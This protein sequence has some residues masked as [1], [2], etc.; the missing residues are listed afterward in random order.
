MAEAAQ[1]EFS[2]T[3][4][5]GTIEWIAKA[6][7]TERV[8]GEVPKE[9]AALLDRPPLSIVWV[10]A[11]HQDRL[12]GAIE[13]FAGPDALV[14]YGLEATR[15][16]FGPVLRPILRG[17]MGLFGATPATIFSRLDRIT[18]V[19]IRGE[20][21][22]FE[23]RSATEGVLTIRAVDRA[24]EVWF[25]A[26][27]GVLLYGFELA[28][29]QGKVAEWKHSPGANEATYRLV[30]SEPREAEVTRPLGGYGPRST[31]SPWSV[32]TSSMLGFTVG[33]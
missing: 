21:Y 8:R 26:W 7:L 24:P 23:P 31:V 15:A 10:E 32:S 16:S 17:L 6:G 13:K 14:T 30:W 1:R 29:A 11:R 28:E 12:L 4:V 22:S 2:G 20:T 25:H 27:G 3:I 19:M 5:R 33:S 18:L 9:T